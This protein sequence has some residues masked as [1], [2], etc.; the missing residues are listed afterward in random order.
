MAVDGASSSTSLVEDPRDA[1]LA[2]EKK[3]IEELT[4]LLESER[5][6]KTDAINEKSSIELE[7]EG[8]SAAL[9]EEVSLS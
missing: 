1:L 8:L 2:A 3:R 5:K 7:L 4:N 9:F 6:A